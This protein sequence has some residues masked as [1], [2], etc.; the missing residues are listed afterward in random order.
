MTFEGSGTV[1]PARDGAGCRADWDLAR[2]LIRARL[3][4][5]TRA[6]GC[7]ARTLW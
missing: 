5:G 7:I 2:D 3:V 6:C 4:L 1:T